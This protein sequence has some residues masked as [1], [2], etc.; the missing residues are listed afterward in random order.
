MVGEGN[1]AWQE[2]VKFLLRIALV[3]A[4]L[5]GR[6]LIYKVYIP[7]RGLSNVPFLQWKLFDALM[8]FGIMFLSVMIMF[9]ALWNLQF[10]PLQYWLTRPR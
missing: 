2:L 5:A 4:P 6:W 9:A 7:R 8:V 3:L 1:L 10:K